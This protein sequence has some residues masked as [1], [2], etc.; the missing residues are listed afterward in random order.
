MIHI[1][2]ENKDFKEMSQA[3]KGDYGMNRLS[4]EIEVFY[5]GRF[6][7][8]EGYFNGSQKVIEIPKIPKRVIVHFSGDD[9]DC[10]AI[11]EAN[12]G[13]VGVPSFVQEK[14]KMFA[15]SANCGL[16]NQ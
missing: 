15:I 5:M 11:A 9:F 7:Y 3:L 4:N 1:D 2:G 13:F 16:N 6:V 14:H 8:F 10:I 12:A